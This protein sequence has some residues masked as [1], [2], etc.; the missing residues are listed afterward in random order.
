MADVKQTWSGDFSQLEKEVD[1]LIKQQIKLEEQL[2]KV[3]KKSEESGKKAKQSTTEMGSAFDAV[4]NKLAGLAASW[5]SVETLTRGATAALQDYHAEVERG[6]GETSRL[7]DL[8]RN[9]L[10]VS[11]DDFPQLLKRSDD[12]ATQYGISR[13]AASELVFSARSEG[14]EG[15]EGTIAALDP[16]MKVQDQIRAAGQVR[17]I[18][19]RQHSAEQII[20]G[21]YRASVESRLNFAPLMQQ[22]PLAAEGMASSGATASETFAMTSVLAGKVNEPGARLKDL[23]SLLA[24]DKRFDKTSALGDLDILIGMSEKDRE[25]L[26]GRDQGKWSAYNRLKEMRGEV[27]RQMGLIDE[28]MANPTGPT[29]STQKRI[30]EF[31]SVDTLAQNKVAQRIEQSRNVSAENAWSSKGSRNKQ[32]WDAMADLFNEGQ[33]SPVEY[34][35]ER[36]GPG[37]VNWFF[38]GDQQA[39]AQRNTTDPLLQKVLQRIEEHLSQA[40]LEGAGPEAQ[41]NVHQEGDMGGVQ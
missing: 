11:Q 39:Y 8:R 31:Y 33:I 35:A 28:D 2:G 9:L 1:K 19:D 23:F 5:V 16:L 37:G 21:A 24:N 41:R 40:T 3:A 27:V 22:I 25:K 18:F 12:L 4:G 26:L 30:D 38:G 17:T 29:S 10:Q 34:Y 13:E 7:E 14:F 20:G 32:F 36:F 15:K 6:R